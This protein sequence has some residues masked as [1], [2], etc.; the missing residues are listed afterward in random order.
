MCH[1]NTSERTIWSIAIFIM[2][3]LI[4]M[5][6]TGGNVQWGSQ[7]IRMNGRNY[8]SRSGQPPSADLRS[9]YLSSIQY[10]VVPGS[11]SSREL[12]KPS[13]PR[14]CMHL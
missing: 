10:E 9:V 14:T 3:G 5:V 12:Q 4:F 8:C 13:G 7:H 2:S 1:L 6:A 11:A